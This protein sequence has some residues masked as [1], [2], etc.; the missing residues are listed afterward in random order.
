MIT[1]HHDDYDNYDDDDDGDDYD[2][3]PERQHGVDDEGAEDDLPHSLHLWFHFICLVWISSLF[4][5]LKTGD[6][7]CIDR[8]TKI[9]QNRHK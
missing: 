2:T 3:T 7:D 9:C 6:V 4:D 1:S 5:K 8:K